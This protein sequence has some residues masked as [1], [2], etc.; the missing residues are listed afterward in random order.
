MG[1]SSNG[2]NG[3]GR[4][5]NKQAK[6]IEEYFIDFN[7]TKAAGRASYSGDY[8]TLAATGSRLLKNDKVA[9]RISQR[10]Q[11]S[12]MS[13]DEVLGRLAEQARNDAGLYLLEDGSLD[14][15]Q[16]IAD[17]KAHLIKKVNKTTRYTKDGEEISK[18]IVELFDAQR[19]LELLGKHHRLFIERR[20][21]TGKGGKDLIPADDLVSALLEIKKRESEPAEG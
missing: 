4:L 9:T 1:V 18:V 12:A 16:L 15:P 3:N 11:E 6:F 10:L 2:K 14:Y 7:A 21:L 13:A 5:T 20:E 19:A 17:G 8:W